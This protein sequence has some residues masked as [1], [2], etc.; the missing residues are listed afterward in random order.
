[1]TPDPKWQSCVMHNSHA[2]TSCYLLFSLIWSSTFVTVWSLQ[3]L[4]VK[5]VQSSIS[6]TVEC[7]ERCQSIRFASTTTY[8]EL[9][10]CRVLEP[11]PAF[12]VWKAVSAIIHLF[13]YLLESNERTWGKPTNAKSTRKAQ[14]GIKPENVMLCINIKR[15]HLDSFWEGNDRALSFIII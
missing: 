2:T 4:Y 12:T 10:L 8:S 11:I 13:I 14:S 3:L 7:W 6:I 5:N 9:E 1:M 15:L